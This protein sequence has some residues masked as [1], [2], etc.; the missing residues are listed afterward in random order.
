MLPAEYQ[1]PSR[2]PS[3]QA[4]GSGILAGYPLVDLRI[5]LTGGS[6]DEELS[7]EIAFRAAGGR[8]PPP[9]RRKA[10]QPALLEPVMDVEVVVPPEYLGDVTGHLSSKRGQIR[11]LEPR[12]D[13]QVVSARGAR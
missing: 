9:R 13:V 11:H 4:C 10:A 7:T 5:R 6:F 8:V 2:R 3:R 1:W 12:G